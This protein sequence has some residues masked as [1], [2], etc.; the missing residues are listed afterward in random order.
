MDITGTD[1]IGVA[2][3]NGDM[4]LHNCNHVGIFKTL[5]ENSADVNA[6]NKDGSTPLHVAAQDN[7]LPILAELE[8]MK[9]VTEFVLFLV[10]LEYSVLPMG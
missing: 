10:V 3:N 7:R 2:N 6:A 9:Y 4:P 5:I 8:K 1:E